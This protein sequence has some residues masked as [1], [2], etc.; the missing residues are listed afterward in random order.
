MTIQSLNDL[1]T[2]IGDLLLAAGSGGL[3]LEAEG[4]SRYALIPLDDNLIDYLLEHS[5]KLI[6]ECRQIRERMEAGRY[7]THG[8]VKQLMSQL[9][10]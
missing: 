1:T 6:E 7:R 5:P 9:H 3:L 2:P 4:Q 10:P 8:E